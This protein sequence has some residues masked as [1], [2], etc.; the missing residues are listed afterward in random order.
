MTVRDVDTRSAFLRYLREGLLPASTPEMQWASVALY[1]LLG[2]GAPATCE[3]LSA[4][5]GLTRERGEQLLAEIPSTSLVVDEH[6]AVIAF[7]GLSLAPTRHLFI[8]GE[9]ELHTWCVLDALFL[10]EILGK[11]AILVTRCPASGTELTVELAPGELRA[12]RPSDLVMS[13]LAPDRNA[14]CANLRAA[15][16]DHVS[17]FRD[18]R[19]FEAWPGRREGMECVDLTEAQLFARQRNAS[20]YPDVVLAA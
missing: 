3:E 7:G 20:R 13:I 16:C 15:F 18:R 6:G 5:C 19:A 8:A 9:I 4:A 17:L 12:A 1:R 2:R 11:S 14:C 10:P